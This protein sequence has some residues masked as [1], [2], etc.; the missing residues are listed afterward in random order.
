MSCDNKTVICKLKGPIR[1]DLSDIVEVYGTVDEKG[2]INCLN[3]A[4]FESNL[5]HDFGNYF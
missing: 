2:N 3:Y 5:T 4:T 1:E